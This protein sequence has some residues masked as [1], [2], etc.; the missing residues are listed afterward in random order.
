MSR[1][2]KHNWAY[3]YEVYQKL[4]EAEPG[5]QVSEFARI[6]G[7]PAGACREAF[8]RIRDKK[9]RTKRTKDTRTNARKTP[10]LFDEVS[11]E[12][13][14]GIVQQIS[15]A[16][17]VAVHAKVLTILCSGLKQL[18]AIHQKVCERD[19]DGNFVIKIETQLDLS[20]IHI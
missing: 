2:A 3:L 6:H 13:T 11:P 19:A 1:T 7:L 17:L 9:A 4:C 15:D 5:T 12:E 14:I 16:R 8:R 18:D 10:T 20:L